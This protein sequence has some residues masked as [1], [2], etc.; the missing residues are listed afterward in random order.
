MAT[1]SSQRRCSWT[2][3]LLACARPDLHDT[4]HCT[5]SQPFAH[6]WTHASLHLQTCKTPGH[7]TESQPSAHSCF[8]RCIHNQTCKA[9]DTAQRV[10]RS[11]TAGS[12]GAGAAP[13]A[14]VRVA[15]RRATAGL[16]AAGFAAARGLAGTLEVAGEARAWPRA[17]AAAGGAEPPG[18]AA[19]AARPVL[20]L[21]GRKRARRSCARASAQLCTGQEVNLTLGRVQWENT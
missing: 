2:H 18:E 21:L 19:G 13:F 15:R 6:S 1:G 5:E 4:R 10:R 14:G 17:G 11:R 8:R 9:P 7:C 3:A 20:P 12:G 16:P